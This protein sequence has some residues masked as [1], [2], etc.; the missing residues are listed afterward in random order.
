MGSNPTIARA[1]VEAGADYLLAVKD[2]QP[3]LKGEIEDYFDTAPA[4]ELDTAQTLDT[5]DLYQPHFHRSFALR[6]DQT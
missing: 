6:F 4:G 1:I 2:N 5:I 3:T